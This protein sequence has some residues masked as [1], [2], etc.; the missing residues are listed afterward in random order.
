[1]TGSHFFPA[2]AGTAVLMAAFPALSQAQ[3]DPRLDSAS[4][5]SSDTDFRTGLAGSGL[6]VEAGTDKTDA[7]IALSWSRED[8]LEPHEDPAVEPFRTYHWGLKA[9]TPLG[10]DDESADFITDRGLAGVG[11][12]EFNFSVLTTDRVRNAPTATRIAETVASAAAA[13]VS[14]SGP[15]SVCESGDPDALQFYMSEEQKRALEVDT[16]HI[17]TTVL[18]I[19]GGVGSK[20]YNFRDPLS[21]AKD[22]VD[23]TPFSFSIQYGGAP[24]VGSS[25]TSGWYRGGGIE[26]SE[27]YE[28]ATAQTLCSPPPPAGPIECFTSPYSAPELERRAVL[29]GVLRREGLSDRFGLTWGA[30]LKAAYDF[31]SEVAGL[32]GTLYMIPGGGALRGGIR[33]KIQTEDDDPLTDD[34]TSSIGLFVGKP[35]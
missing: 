15:E 17:W 7:S 20:S 33:F 23:K 3:P 22:S 31:E 29:Y 13:C 18:S 32:E 25:W 19:T 9:T 8:P 14:E 6:I 26:Y 27:T 16:A 21:L 10:D 12:L 5:D 2:L 4:A 24:Q 34:E 35:F 1:M 30:Q 28:A 11:S